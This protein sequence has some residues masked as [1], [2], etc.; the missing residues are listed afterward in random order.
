[1]VMG[2]N[3]DQEETDET[4]IR[5]VIR[6]NKKN[7][8][9]TWRRMNKTKTKNWKGWKETKIDEKRIPMGYEL[10]TNGNTYVYYFIM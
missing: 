4:N 2:R 3:E 1:M 9:R 6:Q 5:H 7:W 8:R 10:F